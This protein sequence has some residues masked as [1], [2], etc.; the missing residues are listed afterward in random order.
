MFELSMVRSAGTTSTRE[1]PRSSKAD[2]QRRSCAAILC[3]TFGFRFSLGLTIPC[4]RLGLF[5]LAMLTANISN[6]I[7]TAQAAAE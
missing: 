1:W 6:I 7:Q 4:T 5:Q 2:G 3:M